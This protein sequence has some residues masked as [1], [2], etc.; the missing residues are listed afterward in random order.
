[1]ASLLGLIAIG[2][3]T[4]MVVRP[5]P[6]PIEVLETGRLGPGITHIELANLPTYRSQWNFELR[7][8][9]H[10][11][12]GVR[13]AARIEH[14]APAEWR[15]KLLSETL[16]LPGGEIAPTLAFFP[17]HKVGPFRGEVSLY[18]DDYPDWK[19]TWTFS[20]EVVDIPHKGPNLEIKPSGFTLGDVKAGDRRE[21]A[22]TLHNSGDEPV[23]VHSITPEDPSR[24]KIRGIEP[25]QL[26][27]P[28]ERLEV[29]AE[30]T[31]PDI[32]GEVIFRLVIRS[33]ALN[34]KVR[35]VQ[36]LANVVPDY[37][38]DPSRV[39]WGNVYRL[40]QPK[41]ELN[42]T[43][44]KPFRVTKVFS[45]RLFETVSLGKDELASQQRVV[46]R[47]R[48]DAQLGRVSGTIRLSIEPAG[49]EARVPVEMTVT[50][51]IWAP[52]VNF[53]QV[54]RGSTIKK[55]EVRF[56][57]M[58]QRAFRI[59]Q[60]NAKWFT[61]E[62]KNRAGLTPVLIVSPKKNLPPDVYRENILVKTDHPDVPEVIVVAFIEVR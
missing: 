52:L 31:I 20:G 25:D 57:S 39:K 5:I 8:K 33:N 13:L 45:D 24:I 40:K 26:L 37:A 48:R 56:A 41:L 2:V 3:G 27:T 38:P 22:F 62:V 47:L 10:I 58:D 46:L 29:V 61:V 21:R 34:M 59:T 15:V 53:R 16:L 14:P 50:P 54:Q 18:T 17:S 32:S 43:G 35:W 44:I 36:A 23:I 11:D 1:M 4:W 49:V 7:V 6:E 51:A 19:Y 55:R 30:I 9:S 60:W 42:I 12:K 28:G